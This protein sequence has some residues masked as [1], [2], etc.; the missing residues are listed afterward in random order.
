MF[1]T[2]PNPVPRKGGDYETYTVPGYGEPNAT[3]FLDEERHLRLDDITLA[4][5]DRLMAA[6]ARVRPVLVRYHAEM[7]APHGRG[8]VYQ[9]TCQMC[10]KPEDHP[11]HAEPQ[12]LVIS[13]S[14]IAQAKWLGEHG[15]E[16]DAEMNARAAS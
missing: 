13:D 9:G 1:I 7:Q 2:R 16:L 3:V 4:D 14:T 6:L 12:P 15:A 11:L 5:C 10:G 8:R